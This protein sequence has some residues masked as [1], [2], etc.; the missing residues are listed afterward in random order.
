M[1]E[2]IVAIDYFTKFCVA[3]PISNITAQTAAKF[4]FEDVICKFGMPKSIISDHGVNFKAKLFENLC[5]LLNIKKINSSFYHAAGNGMVERVIKS[6]KQILTM[7]VNPHHS[8]WD[9]FLQA[10]ISAYNTS[11][12]SS[13]K[14]SPY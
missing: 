9:E 12:H 8:D 3:K 4:V 6:I 10:S 14:V 11:K 1:G 13:L 5:K 2:I 7:Y